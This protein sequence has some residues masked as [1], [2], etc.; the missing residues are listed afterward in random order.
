MR[1]VL[2]LLLGIIIFCGAPTSFAGD[3]GDVDN[4]GE[5][6]ILDIVY[7]INYKYK[8]GPA[9]LCFPI[10]SCADVDNSGDINILD[11]VYLIN[12]K[13]KEGPEPNCPD[14]VPEL[15]TSAVSAITQTTAESG[16]NI[17]A[18]ISEVLLGP[19]MSAKL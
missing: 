13:Y 1:R 4:S 6:N 10:N 7:L 12:F 19:R 5:V 15:T 16:G 2:V 3:C 8:T 11:I 18:G 17:T 9:P 14:Y